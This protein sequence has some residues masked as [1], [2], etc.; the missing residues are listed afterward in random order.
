MTHEALLF[1]SRWTRALTQVTDRYAASPAATH[2]SLHQY[3]HMRAH[4]SAAT[5]SPPLHPLPLLISHSHPSTPT[6]ILFNVKILAATAAKTAVFFLFC[7]VTRP[8]S[9]SLFP[10]QFQLVLP[11]SAP[12]A[13]LVC[14]LFFFIQMPSR[15]TF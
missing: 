14:S 3:T 2:H 8:P 1:F 9:F 7:F 12:V 4:S 13:F 11:C 10:F 15:Q 5:S 6:E